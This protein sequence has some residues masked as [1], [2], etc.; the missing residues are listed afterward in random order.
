VTSETDAHPQAADASTSATLSVALAE[1]QRQLDMLAR[2]DVSG[3]DGDDARRL[4]LTGRAL[5]DRMRALAVR[6]LPVVEADGRWALDGARTFSSW[7]AG[8]SGGSLAASRRDTRLGRALRDDLPATAEGLVAGDVSLEHAQLLAGVAATSDARRDALRDGT[9]ACGEAFLLHHAKTVPADAFRGLLRRWAAAADPESDERGFRDAAEREYLDVARTLGGYHLQGFLTEEHGMVLAT[10][11]A[12]V[13]GAPAADDART[14]SQRRAAALSDL[15][16]TVLDQGLVG[17]GAAVRPHLSVHVDLDRLA[18]WWGGPG[19]EAGAGTEPVAGPG[20]GPATF[21]DGTP[22]PLGL[23]R[24]LACDSEV[25]RV[26]FGPGRVV[27]DVGRAQRTVTGQLRRAVIARDRH[28]QYPGCD[29]P[30]SRCEVHHPHHWADGGATSVGNSVLLC[31]HHHDLLHRT[32]ITVRRDAAACS[33]GVHG[34]GDLGA[35]D[36]PPPGTQEPRPPEGRPAPP[37]RNVGWQFVDR[38]ARVVVAPGR[39]RAAS[40]DPDP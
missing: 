37:V 10:A 26:V 5:A 13:S 22:V 18:P 33:T 23:L 20:P 28:C 2:V 34:V 16:R 40:R 3:L 6:A 30:P 35:V 27:L 11:L 32:G 21:D 38:N 14:S 25:T 9:S 24:R 1:I 39:T 17:T 7:L 19:D 15:A 36:Q 4:A 8:R 12:A 29:A 31:W